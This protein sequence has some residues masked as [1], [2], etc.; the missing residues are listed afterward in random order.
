MTSP[1]KNGQLSGR[2]EP[3]RGRRVLVTGASGQI[4][5]AVCQRLAAAGNLVWG[6]ARFTDEQRR[7]D[8]SAAG[9]QTCPVDLVDGDLS[10]LPDDVDYVVHMAA[11]QGSNPDTDYSIDANAVAAGRVLSRYRHVEGALVMSTGGV[12]RAHPDP[13][14]QYKESD[15]L[16]DP[17]SP[18]SPA[19]GVTKVAQ[20][21]VAKFCAREFGLRVVIARM[22]VAYGPGG[23]VPARHLGLL[24]AGEPIR[25]R[26]NPTP[27]SPIHEDDITDHLG[28]LLAAASVPALV[29]NFGGDEV[30][31]AQQWCAYLGELAGLEPRF[32][33][34]PL[35]GAQPGSAVDPA[36]RLSITGPDR[37]PWQTG[38]SRMF[39]VRAPLG[40]TRRATRL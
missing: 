31:T 5:S 12:Y 2:A 20:E 22:N 8:L 25:L 39:E 19:Y 34:A 1:A 38:M 40:G 36:R 16:G 6:T 26:G 24:L 28:P 29:V 9:V 33:L 27:Y 32:E 23:G 17:A 35:P 15:P 37:V 11:Y 7:R 18:S 10:V 13:W 4:A 3:L 14:H 30:V 21:A